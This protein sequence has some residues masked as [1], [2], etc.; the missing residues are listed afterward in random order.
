MS[1]TA[2]PDEA[3]RGEVPVG[4]LHGRQRTGRQPSVVEFEG[5]ARRDVQDGAVDRL[6]SRRR[7]RGGSRSRRAPGPLRATAPCRHREALA[8]DVVLE[9]EQQREGIAG[10]GVELQAEGELVLVPRLQGPGEPAD[11]AVDRVA[12]LGLVERR[13]GPHPVELVAPVGQSVRPR[14]EHLAPARV[15]PLVGAESVEHRV[16]P[17]A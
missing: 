11:E 15:R 2:G 16:S 9:L 3:R 5:V 6:G 17:T 10:R 7:D 8:A 1:S 12:A 14:G 13:L 4:P